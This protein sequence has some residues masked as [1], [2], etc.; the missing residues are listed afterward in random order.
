MFNE[1]AQGITW[2]LS[3]LYAS[4]ED[5]KIEVDL[6]AA[7]S[8]A[9]DFEKKYKTLFEKRLD[10]SSMGG[11]RTAPTM[12]N[13]LKDYKEIATLLTKLEVF[14][15]LSFAEKTN[16][17]AVAAFMQKIQVRLTDIA[18]HLI[19]FDVQ[20]N[21]LDEKTAQQ[22]LDD[23]SVEPDR[24]FLQKMRLWAPYTLN[25]GEEKIMAI[26]SNTS[27]NAF[28]RLFDEVMNNIAFYIEQNGARVKKTEG[29]MLALLHSPD[30][31]ERKEASE[32]FAEGLEA[33]THLLTYIHNMILADHRSS[34]KIRGYRHPMDSRNLSNEIDRE[35]VQN[36]IRSVKDA[37]PLAQRYYRLKKK[38]LGLEKLYDYDRYAPLDTEKEKIPFDQCREIVC[39]GYA[40][41]S[42]EAGKIVEQFFSRRW[43]DAEVREGKQGGGF[44]CQTTPELHPYILV[45]YTGSLRD[46][47]TVAHECGHGLHQWL[48]RKAGILESNAPLTMAETASVFGEM[49]IFEKI[50]AQEKDPKKKLALLCGKI[51][52]NFATVFRQIVFTDF[53]I[54]VHEAGLKEGELSSESFGDFWI[55]ANAEMYG[56]S[57]ELTG[58]Y[59]HGWKYISH[60]IHSPFYC[61][62]YAFAQLYVLCLCQVY[63]QSKK[64]FIPKYL[65]MLA[66][67]GSRKPD[68]IA[69][70]VGLNV[71]D[72]HFWSS[73]IDLLEQLVQE[74]EQLAG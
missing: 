35:S 74:A 21:R 36:L 46:V 22:W 73:G 54:A 52:D 41:F 53:E 11:S 40:A 9:I 18:A 17:P 25:E 58:A 27:G 4:P 49:L 13:L 34:L 44:C 56:D 69:A 70:I 15:Q 29:E 14:A 28:S 20:W 50:L 42:A 16:V 72:P 60:F 57:V 66:L 43:I 51:D 33:N 19:F 47:M 6:A 37:Y 48:S 71:R 23:P 12:A 67:G 7:E 39:S 62:A 10:G 38:L 26:K 55:R 5:P 64:T 59:R 1:L 63:K 32:G 31:K 30:R 45:N 3:D 8:K 61:Y 65:E 24:H 68:E 2:D